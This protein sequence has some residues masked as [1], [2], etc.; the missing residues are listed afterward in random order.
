M[1]AYN[2]GFMQLSTYPHLRLLID[3]IYERMEQSSCAGS[4]Y[5]FDVLS[6]AIQSLRVSNEPAH[7][8][9]DVKN[10][11]L[12]TLQVIY[13]L[14][15]RQVLSTLKFHDY[16]LPRRGLFFAI[17]DSDGILVI[18]T[19]LMPLYHKRRR[20]QVDDDHSIIG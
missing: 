7:L 18:D 12:H 14:P 5:C 2:T 19:I 10:L 4:R 3:V 16:F 9:S 17:L 13:L 8:I 11:R 15:I 1:I 20:V 6:C